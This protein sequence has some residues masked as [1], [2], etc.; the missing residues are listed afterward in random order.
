MARGN[1]NSGAHGGRKIYIELH[2][3][4][5]MRC[6]TARLQDLTLSHEAH[7]AVDTMSGSPFVGDL[8]STKHGDE[9][10]HRN[11]MEA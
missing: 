6:R 1:E 7:C 8:S 5:R 11:A 10:A 3:T 2:G 4:E 9:R